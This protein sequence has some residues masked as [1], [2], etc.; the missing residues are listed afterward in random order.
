VNPA[1]RRRSAAL[2]GCVVLLIAGMGIAAYL[3]GRGGHAR[4]PE[5]RG[6]RRAA[7]DTALKRADLRPSYSSH[8]ANSPVGDAISQTP[9]AGQK[10]KD[11]STVQVV[12]SAGPKPVSVPLVVGESTSAAEADLNQAKLRW[13]VVSVPAPGMRPGT[14]KRQSPPAGKSA[15]PHSTVTL[16]VAEVPRWRPLT[17]FAGTDAGRS[18]AFQILGSQFR[19]VYSMDY[20]GS[21]TLIF[22]CAGPP[23]AIVYDAHSGQTLT[24]FDLHE[25]T[26]N[27]AVVQ[28]GPGVYQIQVSP[29]SDSGAHYTIRVQDYY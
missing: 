9:P 17:S 21:C 16:S 3:L 12:L 1:A 25:G 4:V 27:T 20:Q 19:V 15:P 24:T 5:L 11:G 2:L 29:G 26:D 28:S 23:Q 7:V 6:L 13:S 18:V 22:F 8:Y 14:V 10:V